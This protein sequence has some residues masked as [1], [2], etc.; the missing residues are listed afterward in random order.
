MLCNISYSECALNIKTNTLFVNSIHFQWASSHADAFTCTSS[1]LKRITRD[2][3]FIHQFE[4]MRYSIK[5]V[6]LLYFCLW[7]QEHTQH[8]NFLSITDESA[9][10]LVTKEEAPHVR[11]LVLKQIDAFVIFLSSLMYEVTET[12]VNDAS[13]RRYGTAFVGISRRLYVMRRTFDK[14]KSA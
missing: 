11:S 5:P 9:S 1:E 6:W 2:Q 3:R 12:L 7:S 10:G 14:Y 8:C 4:M 13:N